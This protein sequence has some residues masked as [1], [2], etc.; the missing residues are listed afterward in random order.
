MTL[1]CPDCGSPLNVRS[2]AN[3][4]HVCQCTN[5]ECRADWV[6]Q[7]KTDDEA[8]DKFVQKCE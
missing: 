1:A 5:I 4:T 7:G 6:T 3:S 8:A 2:L